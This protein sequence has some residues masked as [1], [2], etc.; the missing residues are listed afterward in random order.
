[1]TALLFQRAK[2]PIL[3][4]RLADPSLPFRFSCLSQTMTP[5]GLVP[6]SQEAC[7]PSL[8]ILFQ[9]FLLRHPVLTYRLSFNIDP[10]VPVYY[11]GFPPA[12]RSR[13]LL[14]H[15]SFFLPRESCVFFGGQHFATSFFPCSIFV[16]LRPVL[17]FTTSYLRL[18][19]CSLPPP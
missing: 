19:C 1:M 17:C 9:P 7:C 8:S 11:E 16:S 3:P 12:F 14:P 6:S 4:P 10:F 5:A 13:F 18:D 15:H 2:G